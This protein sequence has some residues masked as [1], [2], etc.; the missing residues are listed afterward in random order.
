[1]SQ[2]CS[3]TLLDASNRYWYKQGFFKKHIQ[4]ESE[5]TNIQNLH[6]VGGTMQHEM[7]RNI[8][9]DFFKKHMKMSKHIKKIHF[10]V[11]SMKIK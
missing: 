3:K 11:F 5:Q 8:N 9:K 7:K 4:V 10:G 6:F 1:M 2:I